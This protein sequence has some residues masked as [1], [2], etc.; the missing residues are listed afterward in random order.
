MSSNLRNIVDEQ[1][2]QNSL[3]IL[4]IEIDH[5][6]KIQDLP[7]HHRDPFDR[8]L[9]SQASVDDFTLLSKDS[10]FKEYDVKV[11]W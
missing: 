6:L 10:I 8:L 11:L 7:F 4:N 5:I 3:Q 9:I 2:D 1:F